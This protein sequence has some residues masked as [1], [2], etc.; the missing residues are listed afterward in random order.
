MQAR[1]T[2]IASTLLLACGDDRAA[3]GLSDTP[4][5]SAEVG[6]DSAADSAADGVDLGDDTDD[7]AA[8][9][10]IDDVTPLEVDSDRLDPDVVFAAED[11]L[12]TI[13]PDL[14]GDGRA[15]M[16][17]STRT[18]T[19][20]RTRWP[21]GPT[22]DLAFVRTGT[23]LVGTVGDLDA[24]GHPDLALSSAWNHEV[25]VYFG[26]FDGGAKPLADAFDLHRHPSG[27]ADRL[28]GTVLVADLNGDARVDLLVTAP[29]EGEE[30]C[31]G[32]R[33]A[34]VFFGPLAPGPASAV[35]GMGPVADD[36]DD[37]PSAS[38]IVPATPGDC[39]GEFA[40]VV[41]HGDGHA[42]V[43]S[44]SRAPGRVAFALPLSADPTPLADAPALPELENAIDVDDDGV[45]DTARYEPTTGAPR[46]TRSSD[47]A[48]LD[49]ATPGGDTGLLAVD[50]DGD[51]IGA[52]WAWSDTFDADTYRS[53]L[54]LGPLAAATRGMI[55]PSALP[56]AWSG[57]RDAMI[58][59]LVTRG[60]VDGD[61]ISEYAIAN[62]L[63][64]FTPR[65]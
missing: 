53:R 61:G 35:D 32:T 4:D 2:L 6:P 26:P 60:D 48:T 37:G 8:T 23:G 21:D 11:E 52:A 9:D 39:L 63:V 31:F 43:L 20:V 18:R 29:G 15:D 30:A 1:F 3:P 51:G 27:L 14:D 49:L 46:W 65:R 33:S 12:L 38:V 40:F 41:A 25:Q 34:L 55:D 42:L 7:T 24:D 22:T 10:D 59:K 47:G 5:T 50:L 36:E 28:G 58:A 19:F 62:A 16:V 57:W 17:V 64:T 44:T 54:V 45:A 13:V 56:L